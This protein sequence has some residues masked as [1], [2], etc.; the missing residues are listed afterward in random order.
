MTEQENQLANQWIEKARS[1]WR[2]VEILQTEKE[3][4][5]DSVC[6]HCQQYVEKLLKALLT[7]NGVE[8]PRT[9]DIRRL[10]QMAEPFVQGLSDFIEQADKL[11]IY[12]V[13]TRYPGRLLAVGLDQMRQAIEIAEEVGNIILSKL[14]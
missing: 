6:F 5:A 9:H 2:T 1:D 14:D 10:A 11:T 8:A 13:E 4:P 12:G 7:K 3:C